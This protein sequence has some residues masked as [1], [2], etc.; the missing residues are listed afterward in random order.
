[1]KLLRRNLSALL[2]R[3]IL[4]FF[5][6]ILNL[7]QAFFNFSCLKPNK[8]KCEI[9]G[10]GVLKKVKVALSGL[11]CVNLHEDTIKILRIDYLCNKQLENDEKLKKYIAKIENVLRLW[12]SRK[13]SLTVFSSLALSK[14]THLDLVKRIPPSIMDQLNK[15]QNDST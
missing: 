7:L 11:T 10:I 13:L 6:K 3:M 4:S 9:A 14:I 12:R 1:M 15:R 5:L 8:S 2:T